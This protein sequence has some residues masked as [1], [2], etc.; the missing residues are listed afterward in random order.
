MRQTKTWYAVELVG[1][2]QSFLVL[3]FADADPRFTTSLDEAS[4]YNSLELAETLIGR[5]KL[6]GYTMNLK[7]KKLTVTYELSDVFE[8]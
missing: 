4:N 2:V 5:L 3:N 1:G 7:P 8:H 6:K